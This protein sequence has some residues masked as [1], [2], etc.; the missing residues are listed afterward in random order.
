[1]HEYLAGPSGP[2]YKLRIGF[3]DPSELF[4]AARYKESG[5]VAVCARIGDLDHPID[6]ARMTHFVRNTDYGCEMR[7]R[8]WLGIFKSRDPSAAIAQR[9][10]GELRKAN[11]NDELARRLH[12]HAVEEMGYLSE[13]LPTLYRRNTLDNTF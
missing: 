6:F 9:H 7:S 8:F 5:A 13:I 10:A 3:H 1:V 4:G 2:V 12:Q 11:V